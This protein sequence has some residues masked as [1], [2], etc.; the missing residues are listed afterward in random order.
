ML[1]Q[2]SIKS[3]FDREG[4]KNKLKDMAKVAFDMPKILEFLT[5]NCL[6]FFS[7]QLQNQT[8]CSFKT[9]KRIR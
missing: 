5:L 7:K 3:R 6:S 1:D 8:F 4:S 9:R 2:N